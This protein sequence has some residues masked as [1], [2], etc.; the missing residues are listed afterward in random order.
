MTVV[1]AADQL[2]T[3]KPQR[4]SWK[5]WLRGL[6]FI[7]AGYLALMYFAQRS[8]MFPGQYRP[9]P[10]ALRLSEGMEQVWIEHDGSKVE[11]LLLAPLPSKE[12]STGEEAKPAPAKH[13]AVIYTHGNG[14]LIDDWLTELRPY[15]EVGCYV[16]LVEFPGY[17]RSTGKPSE[18]AITEVVTAFSINLP[19][20]PTLMR[21]RSSRMAVRWGAARPV[22]SPRGGPS[23]R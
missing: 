22:C 9:A 14:E 15:R 5:R 11:V 23:R 13:P 1:T 6:V 2:P 7:Y 12:Q 3:P 21:P 17:G 19:R 16:V 10:S 4:P 18:A 20:G 8:I